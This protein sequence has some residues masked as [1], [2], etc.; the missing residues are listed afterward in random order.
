MKC[1]IEKNRRKL[2][3]ETEVPGM[4]VEGSAIS[5]RVDR[6]VFR[7]QY[8][9]AREILSGLGADLGLFPSIL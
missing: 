6:T 1:H 7:K 2:E 9:R 5:K 8:Q 4:K 3:W